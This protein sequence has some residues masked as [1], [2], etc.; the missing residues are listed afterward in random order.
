[1]GKDLKMLVDNANGELKMLVNFLENNKGLYENRN[2]L[3]TVIS[4]N[5]DAL[6]SEFNLNDEEFNRYANE[7]IEYVNIDEWMLEND[8]IDSR[9]FTSENI[10]N[11]RD[12]VIYFEDN[13]LD[14]GMTVLNLVYLN[15]SIDSFIREFIGDDGLV[16]YDNIENVIKEIKDEHALT[17]E[18][19]LEELK[20]T[21]DYIYFELY[22][23]FMNEMYNSIQI[24]K[25]L[26]SLENVGLRLFKNYLKIFIE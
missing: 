21:L 1:M 3:P 16:H 24:N 26:T 7:F 12:D 25:F 2:M 6:M 11:L 4:D 8:V 20:Y 17:R 14:L 10:F 23:D 13:K 19:I 5:K 15:F 9:K 18:C 22:K